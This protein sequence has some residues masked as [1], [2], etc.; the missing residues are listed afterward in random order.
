MTSRPTASST[1]LLKGD[2]EVD[3]AP[4][5]PP[6][7]RFFRLCAMP[8]TVGL[9]YEMVSRAMKAIQQADRERRDQRED[10]EPARGIA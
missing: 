2:D 9:K 5:D 1:V 10:A 6:L 7:V 3:A 4:E 8:T